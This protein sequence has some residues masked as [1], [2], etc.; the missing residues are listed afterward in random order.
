MASNCL[1]APAVNESAES[2]PQKYKKIKYMQGKL[3]IFEEMGRTLYVKLKLRHPAMPPSTI[4]TRE[5]P[6]KN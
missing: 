2:L 5:L 1:L 4:T 3:K 6:P